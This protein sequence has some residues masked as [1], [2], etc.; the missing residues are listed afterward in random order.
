[1]EKYINKEDLGGIMEYIASQA[2]AC[3]DTL[4]VRTAV[5]KSYYD[6][7]ILEVVVRDRKTWNTIVDEEYGIIDTV[8][9]C[10]D[11]VSQTIKLAQQIKAQ[12]AAAQAEAEAEAKEAEVEQAN[13]EE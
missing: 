7:A 11:I 3:I 2:L 5:R 6:L 13:D 1:M 10:Y 12:E 8:C 9:D 4:E